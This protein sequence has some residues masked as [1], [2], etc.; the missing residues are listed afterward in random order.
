VAVLRAALAALATALLLLLLTPSTTPYSP[1]NPGPDGLSKF[2]T[3]CTLAEQADVIVLAPG[4]SLPQYNVSASRN[5][6]VDPFVNDG[7]P[8]APIA[9]A[10]GRPVAAPNAT[11]LAGPGTLV[12]Y[13]SPGS[14]AGAARG[15]FPLALA[16]RTGNKTVYVY[17]AALFSN[18]A[19]DKNLQLAEEVCRQPVKV[20]VADPD[21]VHIL[22]E[23]LGDAWPWAAPAVLIAVSLY[24]I[25][26]ERATWPPRR[27]K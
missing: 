20:V 9:N 5:P 11:P 7:D 17:H 25:M 24:L 13:T 18:R 27:A 12:V 26:I 8:R 3:I 14:F 23:H 16:V 6:I 15:P 10:R 19:I 4:A 21:P 22:H 2:A 1:H